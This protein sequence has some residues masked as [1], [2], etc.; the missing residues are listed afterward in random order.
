M[1][2]R[3]LGETALLD[4][5]YL[6][7]RPEFGSMRDNRI[8]LDGTWEFLHLVE[9]YRS[10][11][12]DWR[13]IA[14]PGPWQAQFADLRM[15]GGTGIYRRRFE[16]PRGWKRAPV[17]QVWRGVSH[18]PGLD[19]RRISRHACRRVS[20]VLVRA[21]RAFVRGAERAQGSGRQ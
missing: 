4:R 15:R 8:Q 13:H 19:Q 2:D 20:A 5:E 12:I 11:P 3:P 7:T 14:V 1:N 16:I 21:D 17:H 9:D 10:R 18:R 6:P